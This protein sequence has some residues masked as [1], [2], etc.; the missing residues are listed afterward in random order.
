MKKLIFLVTLAIVA[1][2]ILASWQSRSLGAAI[3]SNLPIPPNSRVLHRNENLADNRPR[4]VDASGPL[5]AKPR[6]DEIA[7][8]DQLE[9]QFLASTVRLGWRCLI[10]ND[11]G[12]N[13]TFVDAYLYP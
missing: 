1:G 10:K 9:Q 7:A 13:Y 4:P 8:C 12:H 3:R 11:D 5:C 6:P 2:S